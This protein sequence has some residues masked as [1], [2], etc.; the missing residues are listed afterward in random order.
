MSCER[1]KLDC[2][3]P[4][5]Q[6]TIPRH[7]TKQIIWTCSFETNSQSDKVFLD[8][9]RQLTHSNYNSTKLCQPLNFYYK[10]HLFGN[11]FHS[12]TDASLVMTYQS[13]EQ[14]GKNW[15]LMNFAVILHSQPRT[16]ITSTTIVITYFL[17]NIL[18][19]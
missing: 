4:H 3:I 5:E 8:D 18:S 9:T 13:S 7:H 6:E 10:R 2:Q 11:S 15:K 17:M 1:R 12:T 19:T 14:R 16:C